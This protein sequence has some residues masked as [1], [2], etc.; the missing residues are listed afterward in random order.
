MKAYKN[1]E[2]NKNNE[3]WNSNME[4]NK[5]VVSDLGMVMTIWKNLNIF[6]IM[7]KEQN[8]KNPVIKSKRES[9]RK[10]YRL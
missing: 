10:H 2:R 7:I 5:K 6:I 3:K 8:T 4:I 1:Q 9:K